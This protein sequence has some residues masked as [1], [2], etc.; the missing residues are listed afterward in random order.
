MFRNPYQSQIIQPIIETISV[1]VVDLISRRN[2]PV[3]SFPNMPMLIDVLSIAFQTLINWHS[4]SSP[5][6]ETGAFPLGYP[7]TVH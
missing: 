1:D 4:E 6:Y 2:G 5:W 7:A 3:V